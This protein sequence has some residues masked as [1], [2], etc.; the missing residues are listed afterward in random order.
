ME[1]VPV[2]LKKEEREALEQFAADLSAQLGLA[3]SMTDAFL[4]MLRHLPADAVDQP[5]W[6]AS[7]AST[8]VFAMNLDA[9]QVAQIDAIAQALAD[10]RARLLGTD[11]QPV[12]SEAIRFV[13]RASVCLRT[14]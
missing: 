2:R 9:D 3:V 7:G 10:R 1:T 11:Q 14:A 8:G 6:V 4:H 5:G 13:I 12:R